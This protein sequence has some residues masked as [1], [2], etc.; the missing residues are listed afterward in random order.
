LSEGEA[1]A[2]LLAAGAG[3][4]ALTRG[5][6]GAAAWTETVSITAA[7]PRVTV[8]DTVGPGDAFGAGLLAWLWRAGASSRSLRDLGTTELQ[9]ALTYASAAAA[10]QCTRASAWGPT[11]ADIEDLLGRPATVYPAKESDGVARVR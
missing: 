2:H 5:S 6:A 3:C 4:V 1:A 9:T 11:V 8:V 7:A 10:A